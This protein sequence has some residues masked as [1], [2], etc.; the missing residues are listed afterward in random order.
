MFAIGL[1]R[2]GFAFFC[3]K[4]FQISAIGFQ[5]VGWHSLIVAVHARRLWGVALLRLTIAWLAIAR[6]A[7]ARLAVAWHPIALLWVSVARL[8]WLLWL[9]SRGEGWSSWVERSC[10]ASTSKE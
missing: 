8:A 7:I 3:L 1:V 10:G 5:G 6:L 2:G 9:A 4:D